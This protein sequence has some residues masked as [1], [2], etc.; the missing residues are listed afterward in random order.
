MRVCTCSQKRSDRN[1]A[2]GSASR[3]L[4]L[5][6]QTPPSPKG[7]ALRRVGEHGVLGFP[8][9]ARGGILTPTGRK[10]GYLLRLSGSC[11]TLPM[12]K[13]PKCRGH[14]SGGSVPADGN[15]NRCRFTAGRR[16]SIVNVPFVDGLP[17]SVRLESAASQS[18][19]SAGSIGLPRL[20]RLP[21]TAACRKHVTK[22]SQENNACPV[23]GGS[24]AT[25]SHC[26][27]AIVSRCHRILMSNL[28]GCTWLPVVAL[29]SGATVGMTG[30]PYLCG[31]RPAQVQSQSPS[32]DTRCG[33]GH[34]TA[35]LRGMPWHAV[36]RANTLSRRTA[37]EVVMCSS[38]A[39]S[40]LLERG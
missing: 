25:C 28:C 31:G 35:I 20:L 26:R 32:Q 37:R 2:G 17:P 22:E 15:T 36:L 21:A 38:G 12:F 34:S 29:H 27:R 5:S 11:D 3:P 16:P 10:A 39:A 19:N 1:S 14:E 23:S 24:R 6:M 4:E 40:T 7:K 18:V 33:M 9:G 8:R 13:K 30:A